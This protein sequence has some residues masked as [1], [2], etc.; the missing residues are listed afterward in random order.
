LHPPVLQPPLLLHPPGL[1]LAPVPQLPHPICKIIYDDG[2]KA[3][4]Q[5]MIENN[6]Y[7]E[8]KDSF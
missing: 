5:M 1:P 8:D 2:G 6:M 3:T 7:I 4:W